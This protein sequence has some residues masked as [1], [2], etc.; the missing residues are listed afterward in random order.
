MVD[1]LA[2]KANHVFPLTTRLHEEQDPVWV[3]V[4]VPSSFSAGYTHIVSGGRDYLLCDHN[5]NLQELRIL[6]CR[7]YARDHWREQMFFTPR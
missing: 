4:F 6:S 3:Y 5:F 7:F 1:E 2:P